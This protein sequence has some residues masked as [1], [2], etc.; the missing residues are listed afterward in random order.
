MEFHHSFRPL[1]LVRMVK[2]CLRK[3][4]GRKNFTLDQLATL[5]TEIEA[6]LNSRPLT[7]VDEDFQSGFTLTLSDFFGYKKLS[8]PFIGNSCF[9]DE[10]Y[11][12]EKDTGSQ[13][14]AI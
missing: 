8:L 1:E 9:N 5:L 11:R 14:L 6:V 2:Q 4:L 10:D 3:A 7:Y 12:Y 13:L